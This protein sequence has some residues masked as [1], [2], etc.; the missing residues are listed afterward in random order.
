[1]RLKK[2][3]SLPRRCGVLLP[4]ASLPSPWGI[5]SLGRAALEFVDFLAAAGQ[6]C[7]QVLPLGPTSYGDSP[8][9]SFSAFAGNP[10]FIDPGVLEEDG[11]LLPGEGEQWDWGKNP[12]Q[13]DYGLIY[14]NR[15]SLLRLAFSR[16]TRK[17]PEFLSFMDARK[18]WLEDYCL[19]MALKE[20]YEG[21]SWQQW[22]DPLRLRQPKALDRAKKE[23][24]EEM[25][26]WA[27]CQYHFFRQWR[28]VKEY[29]NSR[30]IAIIGDIPIYV[31]MDSADVWVHGEQFQ[32]DEDRRPTHVAG[33]PPD[34]FS[35]TGQLWGNP[36][37]RWE[38][39]EKDGF[40]WWRARMAA[41]GELYDII[42]I[43]HF[44][45][46]VNY[47][48]IPAGNDTA[49]EGRWMP[50]PGDK[51]LA[52]LSD[53]LGQGRIIAEDLGVVTAPVRRL[54]QRSGY[55]GMKVLSFAFDSGSSNPYLPHCYEKN[56]VV[57][58]GTHDN[59]TLVGL[60]GRMDRKSLAFAR[61]YLNVRTNKQLP[62]A[63][64]RCAMASVA[65]TAVIQMQDWLELDDTART[66][67]PSTLGE[68]W[69]WR[70]LPGQLTEDLAAQMK[71]LALVYGRLISPTDEKEEP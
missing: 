41:Q 30:G 19:Y 4:V 29:A 32:L 55:P 64:I 58:A 36:L 13:V 20:R 10:Y 2:Q 56:S 45:G 40:S 12:A 54:Q 39:M 11:L 3:P 59:Q 46:I 69:M 35:A 8:Y 70:L 24:G 43:D 63:V 48:S 27:F 6:T 22:P 49:V 31:A 14:Q 61:E 7:W 42:R 38:V 52:A 26:F 60:F 5:G 53:T 66:N 37:Y 21:R 17:D 9:Q 44:I 62:R 25:A 65:D 50:G 34:L 18:N 23:L 47:Y 68:N 67:T 71:R 28:Q 16:W 57:Y 1:M 15:F 51:L 33:V